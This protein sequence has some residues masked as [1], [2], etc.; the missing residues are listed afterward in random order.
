WSDRCHKSIETETN[1]CSRES[2]VR[3]G[4]ARRQ[5]GSTNSRAPDSR[6][7]T[8]P[9]PQPSPL[10]RGGP[11]ARRLKAPALSVLPTDWR[12][13][14]LSPRERAGVR[15][16][17]ARDETPIRQHRRLALARQT[18]ACCSAMQPPA[19]ARFKKARQ[20]HR[21]GLIR[22]QLNRVDARRAKQ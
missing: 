8:S 9:S 13:F 15:G 12:R 14:S 5:S 2:E 7:S 18:R 1:K 17:N 16:K 3:V 19:L 20:F 11:A 21:V 6:M 22:A 4:P 10:G